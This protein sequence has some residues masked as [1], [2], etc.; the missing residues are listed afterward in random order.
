MKS[1][2]RKHE[3]VKARCIAISLIIKYLPILTLKK[4]GNIFKRDHSTVIYNH[5]LAEDL[6]VGERGFKTTYKAIEA[7]L[8]SKYDISKAPK[9]QLI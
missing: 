2:I 7:Q 9:F 4:V 5:R 1:I 3:I 6:M 8:I